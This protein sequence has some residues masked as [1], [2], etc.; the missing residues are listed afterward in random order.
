M[1]SP[2]AQRAAELRRIINRANHAYYVLDAPEISDAEYDRLLRELQE[3]EAAHPELRSPDSP[4][5]RV[6]TEPQSELKKHTHRVPMLSLANAFSDEELEEWEARLARIAPEVRQ[7]GYELEVKIDGAAVSLTYQR[8]VFAVGATRGNGIVGEEVTA[9]LRTIPDV[10]LRLEGQDVLDWMEVRGEVYFPLDT[11]AE[12]NRRREQAGEPPFANPR[13]AAAGSLRQLDPRITRDRKLRFFAFHI[14]PEERLPFETQTEMLDGLERWGFPVEPHRRRV[15]PLVEAKAAIAGIEPILRTLNFQADGVVLKVDRLSLHAELGVVGG[16]EP[17]WA[18]ARK[19]APEV[20]VTR[21]TAIEVNV[22]R[23]GMLTPFAVLEPVDV[24]GVT[25][26]MATLHNA[27]LIEAKDIRVGDYVEVTRAG[28]VIPQVLGPVREKRPPDARPWKMPDT[29][30]RCGS[31]IERPPDEVAY[32]CP[33]VSCP[34]R[35]LE[36]IAH[37]AGIM[38]VRGLGYQ[39]VQQLLAAGLIKNVAD[40]YELTPDQVEALEGFAQKSARQLVDAIQSSKTQ[41]LSVVLFALG[42]RHVG[43]GVARLLAREFGT[44]DRLMAADVE[45]VSNVPGIGSIIADA[46]VHFFAEPRN[47]KLI[48]R[49]KRYGFMLSEPEAGGGPLSGQTYVITGTLPALSRSE[50]TSRIEAAGGRVAATVSKKT[51]AVV[52]GDNPGSKQERAKALGV[53][54]IDEA[55]LL[56]R[57]GQKS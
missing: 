51:T 9:N 11:F 18:I 16:R 37:F 44:I 26:S 42:I 52:A 50:A 57:I 25:V 41:P 39:R 24:T 48:E 30:P 7:A 54:V 3:L 40:L 34:G 14:E 19:F 49:F 1:S 22:G 45:R 32:Y 55:E 15:A 21:L 23:T 17:R 36:T 38:D 46:V 35:V 6:G 5:H 53:E 28:E 12:L 4:T 31:R 2:P 56:R 33:N 27:D 10:P 43:W 8:G 13:N 29:C 20:A 47:R